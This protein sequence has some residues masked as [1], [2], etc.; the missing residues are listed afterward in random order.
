M[1]CSRHLLS[2][3]FTTVNHWFL[4]CWFGRLCIDT[5]IHCRP[6]FFIGKSLISWCTKNQLTISR[7]SIEAEYRVFAAT[8]CEMQWLVYLIQDL[9]A[10][11]YKPGVL[12]C[13]NLS[14]IHIAPN[15]IFHKTKMNL[16]IKCHIVR[17]KLH[18]N[19]FKL[20]HVS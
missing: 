6:M 13:D 3:K 14:A 16:E 4:W 19:V 11:W 10:S 2:K 12:Y 9:Q 1:P 17:E 15:L 18:A 5:K 20:L 8:K 7:S